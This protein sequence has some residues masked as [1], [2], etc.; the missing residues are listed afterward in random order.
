MYGYTLTLERDEENEGISVA[1]VT[2]FGNMFRAFV[3]PI[4]ARLDGVNLDITKIMHHS[5]VYFISLKELHFSQFSKIKYI[6]PNA[7]NNCTIS[8]IKFF[9][10]PILPIHIAASPIRKITFVIIEKIKDAD[11]IEENKFIYYISK[12]IIYQANANSKIMK[13]VIIREGIEILGSYSFYFTSFKT[14]FIADSVKIICPYCFNRAYF[15]KIS[16]SNMSCLQRL[17]ICCFKSACFTEIVFPSSLRTI[18]N[19]CFDSVISL[20]RIKFPED[21]HC[22]SIGDNAFSSTSI[23]KVFFPKSLQ[24][25]GDYAFDSCYCLEYISFP[26]YSEIISISKNAFNKYGNISINYPKSLSKIFNDI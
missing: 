22:V 18:G 5:F 4:S 17:D 12:P 1:K 2:S 7:F 9:N 8:K 23:S 20:K 21:S 16:F 25:I 26:F 15:K 3:F 19:N 24:I 13:N 10:L 14:I 11:F 6:D